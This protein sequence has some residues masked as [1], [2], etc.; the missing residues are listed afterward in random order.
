MWLQPEEWRVLK[1]LHGKSNIM[2]SFKIMLYP[3]RTYL[4]ML[5]ML[6]SRKRKVDGMKKIILLNKTKSL[7]MLYTSSKGWIHRSAWTEE[8]GIKL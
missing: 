3:K 7:N 8:K 6:F 1:S 2:L 5:K 4:L